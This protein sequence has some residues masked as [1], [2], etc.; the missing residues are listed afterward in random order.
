MFERLVAGLKIRNDD[1][2]EPNLIKVVNSSV[3]PERKK[4]ALCMD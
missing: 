2:T 3:W 4:F 1:T